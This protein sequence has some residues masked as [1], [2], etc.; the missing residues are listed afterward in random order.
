[1]YE[2]IGAAET[3]SLGAHEQ[4]ARNRCAERHATLDF[5]QQPESPHAARCEHGA[6]G[7]AAREHVGRASSVPRGDAAEGVHERHVGGRRR[8]PP[9]QLV[10]RD[11]FPG[12]EARKALEEVMAITPDP[13]YAAE[14][15]DAMT[16]AKK[17]LEKLDRE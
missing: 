9:L 10:E 12:G 7:F 2:R 5:A 1:M 17:L 3:S 16:K 8:V 14:H 11:A 6:R 4:P 13:K 15:N